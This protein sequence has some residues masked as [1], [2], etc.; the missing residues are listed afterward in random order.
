M[1]L[2]RNRFQNFAKLLFSHSTLDTSV[3]QTFKMQANGVLLNYAKIG[4]GPPL[5]FIHGWTN[6][7]IG[8]VPIVKYLK[9]R[10]TL[11]LI[12]LPGFGDSGH[13]PH[14]SIE[15]AA[16]YVA[17]FI[18]TLNLQIPAVIGVSMGSFVAAEVA[19]RYPHLIK[20]SILTGPVLKDN[21]NKILPDTL[22]VFLQTIQ[23]S[24]MSETALKRLIETR[25]TAYF[26][27]K[28]MNMYK[29]KQ[30]LVDNYG[31]IGKKKLTKEAYVEMG[32]SGSGYNLFN[33]L[34]R[35]HLPTQLII[36]EQ[37]KFTSPI[38]IKTKLLPMNKS[39]SLVVIPKAGHVV[40][41]EKPS[42]VAK[43][44]KDFLN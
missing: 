14:Y 29:F 8:W 24:Q 16:D 31:M 3:Y 11:Y 38:F 40:A 21:H 13:L 17:A 23:K 43:A 10:F 39:L 37:D 1:G 20:T 33:K 12:D 2:V 35:L 22:H 30:D 15:I 6:N 36:G 7:W 44:I 25:A 28:Y 18:N 26:L 4:S 41:W 9:N 5:I 27:A 34:A 42:Q 32:I 19:S